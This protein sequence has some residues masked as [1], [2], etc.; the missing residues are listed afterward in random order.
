MNDRTIKSETPG[1]E[2]AL[3]LDVLR[4]YRITFLIVA[5]MVLLAG[6]FWVLT[7]PDEYRAEGSIL[8]TSRVLE[9]QRSPLGSTLQG[10]S[11]SLGLELGA[12]AGDPSATIRPILAS[13]QFFDGI[14]TRRFGRSDGTSARLDSL[15][16]NPNADENALRASAH[17]RFRNEVLRI[18]HDEETGVT[19][20]AAILDDPRTATELVAA[21]LDGLDQTI[22]AMKRN[23]NAEWLDYLRTRLSVARTALFDSEEKHRLFLQENRDL[24]SPS[25]RLEESRLQ[26]EILMRQD[27]YLS[28]QA[29]LEAANLEASKDVSV[30]SII[31]PP[32]EPVVPFR[33]RRAVLA[34]V[35][36]LLAGASATSAVLLRAMS[37]RDR[38]PRE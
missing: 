26:R 20:I 3:F 24:S 17:A 35:V 5:A 11:S 30:F 22:L 10:L 14:A 23:K 25:L 6:M 36:L 19:T 32:R 34:S 13:R 18:A 29:Q 12:A 21:C 37:G 15:L 4:R 33:P 7:R 2:I 8:P 27:V 1:N 28:I 38:R 31:D 16:G 9:G